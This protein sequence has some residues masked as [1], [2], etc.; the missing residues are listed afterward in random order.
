MEVSGQLH[1]PADLLPEKS[2]R[3]P[4]DRRLGVPQSRSGRGVGKKNS[5][6]LPKID[7]KSSSR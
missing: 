2:H 5:L 4:F 3:Y 1:A 6:P 7:S